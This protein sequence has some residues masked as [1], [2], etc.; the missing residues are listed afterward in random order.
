MQPHRRRACEFLHHHL[1]PRG[2]QFVLGRHS[3]HFGVI[4]IGQNKAG[5]IRQ[6]LC[7]EGLV[8][9]PE[10]AVTPFQIAL[11]FVIGLE[12]GAAGFAL[13]DP[14]LSLGAKGHYINAETAGGHQF[15]DADKVQ[16]AQVTADAPRQ[17]L[18]GLH[19]IKRVLEDVIG[20]SAKHEQ[21]M[22]IRQVTLLRSAS[23]AN[24]FI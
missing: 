21:F 12:I 23:G 1:A 8:H 16:C 18:A 13:N 20:H 2:G 24:K 9:S 15:L 11:P 5:L 6:Q 19:R 22:N 4:G 10:E 14:D 7:G 17:K 3:D